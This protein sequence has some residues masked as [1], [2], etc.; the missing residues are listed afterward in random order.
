MSTDFLLKIEGIEGESKVEGYSGHIDVRSLSFGGSNS[1]AFSIGGGGKFTAN[2]LELTVWTGRHTP[3]VLEACASGRHIPKVTLI[4]RR[5]GGGSAVEYLKATLS[6][7]V[8]TKHVT[9]YMPGPDNK[10]EITF[11]QI[12]FNYSKFSVEH[13]EKKI[14]GSSGPATVGSF[15]V[16]KVKA[17]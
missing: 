3:K 17:G 9:A 5:A 4:C 10:D 15:D 2:D 7:V 14:D 12:A 6:D 11:D 13:K 16:A 1:G 8:V